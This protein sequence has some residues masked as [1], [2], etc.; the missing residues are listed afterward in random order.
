MTHGRP[1]HRSRRRARPAL[2]AAVAAAALTAPSMASAADPNTRAFS[3]S[4]AGTSLLTYDLAAPGAATTTALTGVN[5]GDL[6]VGVAVRP[7]TA[8]LYAVGINATADTVQLYHLG[9]RTGTATPVGTAAG[10]V[11][12]G[13]NPIDLASTSYGVAF[14]PQADRVRVVGSSALNFRLNPNTGGVVDSDGNAGNGNQTD[15]PTNGLTTSVDATGY[16]NRRQNATVTT[17]YTASAATDSLYIQNAPNAG[18]QTLPVPLKSAGAPLDVAAVSGLDFL[19]QVTAPGSNAP[20]TGK[21]YAALQTGGTTNLATIDVASGEVATIGKIGDGS[22]V[23]GLAVQAEDVAGGIPV[24]AYAPPGIARFNSA[25]PSTVTTQGL[26]AV[27]AGETLV[28]IARRPQTGQF[29]GLGVDPAANDATLYIVDPQVGSVTA[30]GSGGSV[31]FTTDGTTPVD[32]PDPAVT[33]YGMDFNPTV[34]RI[35]VVTTTGLNFRLNPNTGGPVDG[36]NGGINVTGTNPDGAVNG[37]PG[38]SFGLS[39]AAYTNSFGQPLTGGVTTQYTL[40]PNSNALFIQNPPNAG[41]QTTQ[42]PITLGGSPLDFGGRSGFDIASD[43][44]ITSSGAAAT[45]KAFAGFT[46]GGITG[47]YSVDLATGAATNAG[48]IGTGTLA[49]HSLSIGEPTPVPAPPVVQPTTPEPT[50]PQPTTPQ[51]TTPLPDPAPS[52]TGLSV[53]PKSFRTGKRPKGASKKV[54]TGTTISLTLSEAATVTFT[55]ERKSSGRTQGGVCKKPSKKNRKGK[56]CTR[57]TLSGTFTATGVAG[58]N[59]IAFSGKIGKKTLP[60]ASYRLKAVAADAAKQ[61]SATSET[62]F[63]IVR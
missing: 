29:F 50:T 25:S 37:L 11:D 13:N 27:G 32:L 44:A 26:A 22:A 28:A 61:S 49:V 31:S 40:D 6:L 35:R 3:L 48:T 38:G 45:G 12:L 34:D 23:R 62:T 8:D 47:L 55:A 7:Q 58:K 30:V 36:N 63:A 57:Y 24:V 19:P 41:T 39:A 60:K 53:S 17:Q 33:S 42:K 59:A 43:V 9:I 18:T 4:A 21:A 5:A 56:K 20:A 2:A 1:T 51:P 16:V 10:F 54:K 46:I 15:G 14:N 52:L